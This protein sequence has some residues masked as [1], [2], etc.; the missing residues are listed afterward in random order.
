M[1]QDETQPPSLTQ[2][3]KSPWT[4]L[5]HWFGERSP[6]QAAAGFLTLGGLIVFVGLLVR[7]GVIQNVP[8]SIVFV[9]DELYSNA[10]VEL[11]SIG[12]TVLVIDSLN[13]RQAEKERIVIEEA[14]R[15]RAEAERKAELILQLGSPDNGFAR[16]AARLLRHK[17][18][19][20]D[21]SLQGAS[22]IEANL[23]GEDLFG[24]NLKGA[25]L[26]EANLQGTYLY[27]ANLQEAEL[28]GTNL[29]GA[30]LQI[31]NLQ[32]ANL[33][34]AN[35][36][37]ANLR[38]ANLKEANLIEANLQGARLIEANLQKADLSE[39]NLQGVNLRGVS[40]QEAD[41]R[42][43]NLQGTNLQG[44][45]FDENTILPDR[46]KWSPGRDMREFTHPEEWK[47][48]QDAKE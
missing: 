27:D 36:Q 11:L 16:E 45:E 12:L 7:Q 1:A 4:R 28:S 44:T 39:A 42:W 5:T 37:K 19:L 8:S 46:T 20:T 25:K 35:L 18:W 13:R 15:Q 38:A 14:N 29:Q 23:Q 31:A 6:A 9:F 3:L 48:E 43:V 30:D 40:L 26:L 21:G 10:G 41:L 2:R 22:L 33:R 17:G 24:A 34:W 32:G 47:A